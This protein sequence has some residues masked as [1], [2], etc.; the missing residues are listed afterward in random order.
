MNRWKRVYYGMSLHTT[1]ACPRYYPMT[2]EGMG[3]SFYEP[4]GWMGDIDGIQYQ[5]IFDHVLLSRHPR[6][7]KEIRNY[8]Y[9]QYKPVQQGVFIEAIDVL[10]GAIFQD[11]N[12]TIE[13]ANKADN[14]YIWGNNFHGKNFVE[15]IVW[16]FSHIAEDPNGIFVVVPK[17]PYH[18]T[19]TRD[20][21]PDVWFVSSKYFIYPPGEDVL[22]S[23]DNETYWHLN[24]IGI[25]RY[26]KDEQKGGVV[27]HPDDI[28]YGG[29]YTHMFGKAPAVV[30]GG[31]WN[32]AGYY[33]SWFVKAK[34]LADELV[35]G[36]SAEVLV[37]KEASHPFIVAADTEC[38]HCDNHTGWVMERCEV[39]TEHPDGYKREKCEHCQGGRISRN[40]GQWVLV[41]Y[42]KMGVD[43]VKIVNPETSIN[44]LHFDKN[45]EL[46]QKLKDA[47][48]LYRAG[49]NQSSL[50]K[51]LDYENK[52]QFYGKVSHDLFYR[53]IQSLLE[54][55]VGYRHINIVDQVVTPDRS[56]IKVVAPT[57]FQIKTSFDLLEEYELAKKA[58]VPS[59]ALNKIAE[60]FTDKQF[61]GDAVM[62]RKA[63]LVLQLDTLA[64][65]TEGD[66]SVMLGAG[67]ILLENWQYSV[68]L[69]TILDT[70]IRER[71]MD[72]FLKM[73][74]DQIKDMAKTIF[75]KTPQG[76]PPQDEETVN[77]N[78]A[79]V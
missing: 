39:S 73:S 58:N 8:R 36:K 69:P 9:M 7:P 76:A 20:I 41:P 4:P 50:A 42:E 26:V 5:E 40:P 3:T 6:E 56:G 16:A 31:K 45:S 48:Y 67:V 53:V 14:D 70:I 78:R 11:S 29:Y 12:Y 10:T 44:Q 43:M 38:T 59:F 79:I 2:P 57:Q 63:S 75:D 19:T 21:H 68:Q 65:R 23:F 77:Q 47:L 17:E 51:A 52:Y 61:G 62:R 15:Y 54:F 32:T 18:S 1:G 72:A 71:G 27:L 33:E 35:G 22:F 30:G 49:E 46:F 34:A 66:K 24:S 74:F 28:A 13:I 60:D 37:D 25:F 55:I 64:T